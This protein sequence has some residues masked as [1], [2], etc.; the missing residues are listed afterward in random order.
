[1]KNRSIN[2]W[3]DMWVHPKKTIRSLIDTNPYKVII[4]LAIIGGILSAFGG[5]VYL[6]VQIPERENTH[7]AVFVVAALIAGGILGLI[8]LYFGGWLYTLTGSWIG[9]KGNFTGV[10]CAV[11][12]SN[13]PFILTHIISILSLWAVPNPWLQSILGLI[14]LILVIWGLVIFLNML[15]EAHRFSAWKALLAIII[16]YI[17]IFVALMIIAL[18]APLLSPLFK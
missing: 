5:I 13:W 11:G 3:F 9:G 14:D 6:W 12:W 18:L 7:R 4:W 10:K 1:M 2:P 17:L 8:H 15:G 16:A